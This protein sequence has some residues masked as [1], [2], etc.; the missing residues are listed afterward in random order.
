MQQQALDLTNQTSSID[1]SALDVA[2]P[3]NVHVSGT[4]AGSSVRVLISPDGVLPFVPY[5]FGIQGPVRGTEIFGPG[6][7]PVG[8]PLATTT[9]KLKIQFDYQSL[10]ASLTNQFQ[11]SIYN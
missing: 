5:D 3:C 4:L 9:Y 8:S 1:S 10:S 2:G 6:I 11:V 7:F